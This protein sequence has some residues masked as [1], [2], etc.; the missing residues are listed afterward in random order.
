MSALRATRS[1]ALVLL[2]LGLG[3]PCRAGELADST[4]R[5]MRANR[6]EEAV[7]GVN[8]GLAAGEVEAYY[9]T[10]LMYLR[11]LCL[12]ADAAQAPRYLEPAAKA[13][14]ADAAR[15]LTMMHGLGLGVP[16]S[17]AQAGRWLQAWVD[18]VAVRN[19]GVPPPSGALDVQLTEQRGVLGTV[20]AAVQERVLYPRRGARLQATEV[21][22][23]LILELGPEGL[24]YGFADARSGIDDDVQSMIL[25]RSHEPH[26]EA[27]E[28]V[29]DK[30]LEELPPYPRPA[31]PQRIAIPYHFRLM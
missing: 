27:I 30:V 25:R 21:N 28:S 9:L 13:A 26:L 7:E 10:G 31:K 5:A 24:R 4:F 22:V 23:K 29:V 2:A 11:G 8:K 14:N 3:A 1:T 16:Q 6:C 17:Y 15:Y 18:I 20:A 12:A 19:Q